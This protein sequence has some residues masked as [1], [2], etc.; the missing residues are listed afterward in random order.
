MIKYDKHPNVKKRRD[1]KDMLTLECTVDCI[2][3]ENEKWNPELGSRNDSN[4]RQGS[5]QSS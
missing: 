4:S 5:K 1:Y 3:K 2:A